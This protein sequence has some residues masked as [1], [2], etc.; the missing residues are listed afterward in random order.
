MTSIERLDLWNESA[1][2]QIHEIA[3]HQNSISRQLEPKGCFVMFNLND[4]CHRFSSNL[5]RRVQ[6]PTNLKK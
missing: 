5:E 4:L 6:F 1:G 3:N 2:W